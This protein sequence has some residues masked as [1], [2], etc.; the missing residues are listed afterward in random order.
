MKYSKETN[1]YIKSIRKYLED[2]YGEVKPEWELMLMLLGDN[3]EMYRKVSETLET[4][5]IYSP[6]SG[7]KNPLLSTQKD[8][9]AS[10]YKIVQHFGISPYAASK[11]KN[12]TDD[13]TED[14]IESLTGGG[15]E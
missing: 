1:K 12:G 5:G 3:V 10:I 9:A 2:T 15:D 7:V 4:N 14:F 8:I 11:I 6:V 13:D